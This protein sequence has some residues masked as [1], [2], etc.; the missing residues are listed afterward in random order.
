[1]SSYIQREIYILA[2]SDIANGAQNVTADGSSFEIS[3][4][5]PIQIPSDAKDIRVSV[6]QATIWFTTVNITEG[7]NDTFYFND[8]VDDIEVVVPPGL[9]DA[10]ALNSTLDT[11]MK[12]AGKAAGFI[13]IIADN[14]TQK[15]VLT[16]STVGTTVDF[17]Q[18]DTFRVLLGFDSQ[19][20][21]ASTV[22][23][24]SFFGDSVASFGAIGSFLI[25]SD[26]TDRGIRINNKFTQTVAQ[27]FINVNVGSQ[28]Q[29]EPQNPATSS[30]KQLKGG[31]KDLIRFWL[32]DASNNLVNTNSEVWTSM[33]KIE[34]LEK[35]ADDTIEKTVEKLLKRLGKI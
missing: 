35:S 23:N 2:S 7:V 25:H 14:A 34:W 13:T 31:S 15:I 16:M 27:V 17:T 9:Y 12:N 3:L 29:F 24:E 4:S 30:G 6:V 20:L 5:Q 19:V 21:G 22:P 26:L 8:G 18:A 33:M 1:M 28:I 11:L 32:T 10:V